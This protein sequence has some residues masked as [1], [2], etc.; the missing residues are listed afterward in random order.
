MAGAS[1]GS[2]ARRPAR[3][4]P[5]AIPPCSAARDAAAGQPAS[6]G[7][8]AGYVRIDVTGDGSGAA[9]A[10]RYTSATLTL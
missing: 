5:P 9:D 6:D 3:F 1:K 10:S 7:L 4:S 8:G 2:A